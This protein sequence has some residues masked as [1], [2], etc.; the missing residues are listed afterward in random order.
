[1]SPPLPAFSRLIRFIPVASSDPLIGSPVDDNLDVGL[2]TYNGEVEV[3]VYSGT[4]VLNPGEKVGRR[5]KVGRILSPLSKEE[6]GTIRCIGLNV[7][8][9]PLLPSY[10][11]S[12]P[13]YFPLSMEPFNRIRVW[14]T[15]SST[16]H[17]TLTGS[18]YDHFACVLA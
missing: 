15:D 7:G 2:A 1:M 18:F 11:V 6:V 17:P 9:T 14:S 3:E 12:L 8:Y 5:E 16:E 10:R 13:L 4:S